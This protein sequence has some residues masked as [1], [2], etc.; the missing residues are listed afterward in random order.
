MSPFLGRRSGPLLRTLRNG[1][2]SRV[3]I[4]YLAF[5]LAEWA[6]WISVLV[7]AFEGGGIRHTSLVA[8]IQ[9]VPAAV[10]ASPAASV[11]A[12][13]TQSRALLAGYVA[14]AFAYLLVA[15]VL[16]FDAPFAVVATAAAVSSVSVTLSRPVHN[17]FVPA[18]SRTTADLTAGNAASGTIEAVASFLGPLLCGGLLPHLGPQGVLGASGTLMLAAAAIV[19]T[20]GPIGVPPPHGAGAQARL[21][22]V[23]SNPA[24]RVLGG[25]VAAEYMLVG[26]LDILLVVLALDVLKM[27]AAGPGLLNSALGL[28]GV[29]GAASTLLLAG[30]PRMAPVLV[31]GGVVAGL[32]IAFASMVPGP[33]SAGLLVA[34]AGAGKLVFDVASRTLAQR[35]LPDRLLTGLFGVQ[36]SLMMA[37][38]ASGA[39]AASLL[40]SFLGTRGAFLG[41]GLF[42]PLVSLAAYVALRRLDALTV[43]PLDVL[44]LLTR[45]PLLAVLAPRVLERLALEANPH[46]VLSGAAVFSEGDSGDAFYVIASGRLHVRRGAEHLRDL[47][48]GQWFGELAVLRDVTRTATVRAH[49]DVELWRIDRDALLCSVG[50]SPGSMQVVDAHASEHYR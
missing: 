46:A 15:A 24:S 29:L 34:L 2:L 1:A 31:V 38:L 8:L 20:L 22:Q 13:M 27:N 43:V 3:L 41:A 7:W 21:R 45:V 40:V 23:L 25:L 47:G 4:A 10:L 48:P 44:R 11:C 42:L 14:Q 12:R 33:W 9:L 36:E 5:N 28:G 37:G 35:L 32:P 18:I 39:I 17:A 26:M 6:T 16:T 49:T 19:A 50:V 30:R